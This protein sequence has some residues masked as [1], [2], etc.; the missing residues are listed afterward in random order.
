MRA[1]NNKGLSLMEVVVAVGI[2]SIVV[3]LVTGFMNIGVNTYREA[4]AEISVQQESQTVF[5]QMEEW[6]METGKGVKTYSYN[7]DQVTAI[8][9]KDNVQLIMFDKDEAK[10]YYRKV[11]VTSGIGTL[12]VKSLV[13]AIYNDVANRNKY[14]LADY[15]TNFDVDITRVMDGIVVLKMEYKTEGRAYSLRNKVKLRNKPTASADQY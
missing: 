1:L 15:I 6:M 3:I 9:N 13:D 5:N 12:N 8:F 7:F 10:L 11:E 2:S 14:F 4:N